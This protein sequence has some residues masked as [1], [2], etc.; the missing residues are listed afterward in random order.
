MKFLNSQHV[1]LIFFF[2]HGK[3]G[4]NN[5]KLSLEVDL[6]ERLFPMGSHHPDIALYLSVLKYLEKWG[7]RQ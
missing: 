4:Q 5:W 1:E 3:T 6:E 7:G 2:V